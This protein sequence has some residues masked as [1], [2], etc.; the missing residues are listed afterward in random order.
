[1]NKDDLL[2]CM[3]SRIKDYSTKVF[4]VEKRDLSYKTHAGRIFL[5]VPVWS[6]DTFIRSCG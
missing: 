6:Y 1:M 5:E 4:I 3:F 2:W